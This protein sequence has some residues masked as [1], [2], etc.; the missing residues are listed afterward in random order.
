MRCQCASL[1]LLSWSIGLSAC[2]PDP[3]GDVAQ[4]TA[5]VGS[6]TADDA[7]TRADID[8]GGDTEVSVAQCP[9][10]ACEIGGLCFDPGDFN[11]SN[12]C[13]SC[14]SGT[15]WTSQTGTPCDDH[16]A[17]T[18]NDMCSAGQCA[19]GRLRSDIGY[20]WIYPLRGNLPGPGTRLL[21]DAAAISYDAGFLGVMAI[22]RRGNSTMWATNQGP[23]LIDLDPDGT[24]LLG[25][26]CGAEVTIGVHEVEF[27]ESPAERDHCVFRVS[28]DGVVV[29]AR[30]VIAPAFRRDPQG[31][32]VGYTSTHI[33]TMNAD[34]DLA[35]AA[36]YQGTVLSLAADQQGVALYLRADG[37]LSVKSKGKSL[38][39][40]GPGINAV[41][42]LDVD[43]T[44]LWMEALYRSPDLDFRS[45][46]AGRIQ[47]L[48]S[49][50]VAV[51]GEMHV[52]EATFGTGASS[53]RYVA[54]G[55]YSLDR[56]EVGSSGDG[57]L[58]MYNPDGHL[59]WVRA[60]VPLHKDGSSVVALESDGDGVLFSARYAER[61]L[62]E[63][64]R[65]GVIASNVIGDV[66]PYV[67][68]I[69]SSIGRFDM[70]GTL[71]WYLGHH[72]RAYGIGRDRD[73]RAI[74]VT[75]QHCEGP[76]GFDLTLTSATECRE[77]ILSL[78]S[79]GGFEC[80]LEERAPGQ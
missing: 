46:D 59:A 60:I 51:G 17:C 76:A 44:L 56:P 49:G 6:D 22:E 69:G 57:F 75:L 24:A 7:E 15:A 4:D 35:W 78:N 31:H 48:P 62:L 26:S 73:S 54:S 5:D 28:T 33:V 2:F 67:G 41:A 55:L 9:G 14:V 74:I 30:R 47:M 68:R 11:P 25:S 32:L 34:G 80:A 61:A 66:N 38:A 79:N 52:R 70:N 50:H 3:V 77:V 36:E 27:P 23:W 39:L 13:E 63:D 43:G 18:E 37:N 58:V 29:D 8:A 53:R 19:P 42:R 21:I 10:S 65:D 1:A 20:D 71:D 12:R 45:L 64:G 16:D 40:E 72:G